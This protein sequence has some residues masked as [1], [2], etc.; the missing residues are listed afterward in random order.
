MVTSE[1][2]A[3][4]ARDLGVTP[5][6]LQFRALTLTRAKDAAPED[7]TFDF[8][9]SSE[10][11]VERWWGV[12]VLGHAPGECV[13]DRIGDGRAPLLMDHSTRDQVGVVESAR[14]EDSVLRGAVRFGRSPRAEEIFRDVLDGIRSQVSIGYVIDEVVL[15]EKK[16]D[17]EV[18]RATKW[19]PLEVSVVA[20][21]ADP[22]VGIGR[23]DPRSTL[24]PPAAP[25]TPAARATEERNM[26]DNDKGGAPAVALTPEQREAEVRKLREGEQT[27][28]SDLLALGVAHG[29]Q[30]EAMKAIREGTSVADFKGWVLDNKVR[31]QPGVGQPSKPVTHLDL[32]ERERKSWSLYRAINGHLAGNMDGIEAEASA[33]IAKRLGRT[34]RG[35]FAPYDIFGGSAAFADTRSVA[36]LVLERLAHWNKRD[37]GKT[38]GGNLGASLVATDLLVGSF[39]EILRNRAKVVGLGARMLT[40]LVGDVS[41]PRQNAATSVGW[42]ATE[43]ADAAE[44]QPGFD[45][46]ALTPKTVSAFVEITRRMLQQSSLSVEALTRADLVAVVALAIDAAAINGSGASGQ[47]RGVLNQ[48]G[49]GSVTTGAALSWAEVVAFEEDIE[50]ANADVATMAWLTTP[51]V[52]GQAKTTEKATNTAV[53]LMEN[54]EMNGYP[55]AV[56]NQVPSN[57][58]VGTNQHALIFGDWAQLLIGEWGVLDLLPDPFALAKSGGL[59]LHVYQDVDTAVRHAGSFTASTELI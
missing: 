27:R 36:D 48:S 40:G 18:Y 46:V 3:A 15:V 10:E 13:L 29:A 41:I 26:G 5:E 33:E 6:R 31:K 9:F 21:A 23:A 14:L 58:G 7:R 30:E 50:T 12:E 19:T 45:A 2:L 53:F 8:S 56:S 24:K 59:R 38:V 49:I 39:I 43:G 11:P 47:P 4:L 42:L 32:S 51:H 57:L 20:V 34:P 1:T 28:A 16:G 55:M 54:G 52:K 35:F 44:G 17:R 22:T 37:V 25:A